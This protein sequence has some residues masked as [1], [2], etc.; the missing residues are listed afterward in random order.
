MNRKKLDKANKIVSDIDL[1][2][3]NIESLSE[4]ID[5][6]RGTDFKEGTIIFHTYNQTKTRKTT[7]FTPTKDFKN[8]VLL[9]K[10][11]QLDFINKIRDIFL[12]RRETL[13][14]ELEKL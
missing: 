7:Y 5:I 6:I 1:L 8:P 10:E 4:Q 13:M 3:R 11:L 2:E 9:P 12:E 14:N